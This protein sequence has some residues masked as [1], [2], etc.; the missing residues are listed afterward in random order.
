MTTVSRRTALAGGVALAAC[1]PTSVL[2]PRVKVPGASF[3]GSPFSFGVASGD[4]RSDAVVLWTALELDDARAGEDVS[5]G[6]EVA[7]D[8]FFERVLRSGVITARV[9]AGHTVKVDVTELPAGTPLFYRFVVP[10]QVSTIGK[11]KTLPAPGATPEQFRFGIGCC[12]DFRDGLFTAHRHAAAESFDAFFFLG[13]FIYEKNTAGVRQHDT[14]EPLDLAGYRARYRQYR[15]DAD[16][17]ASLAS[18]PWVLTWDDHEVVNDYGGLETPAGVVAGFSERRAAAYRAYS[19]WTPIRAAPADDSSL[20]L[21]RAFSVGQLLDVTVLDT[22]QYRSRLVCGGRSGPACSDRGRDDDSILGAAQREWL[23]ERLR[24]STASWNVMA[25]QVVF[26]DF[27][28]ANG[29]FLNHDQWDGYPAERNRVLDVLDALPSRNTVLLTG[30]IHL[31]AL[32]RVLRKGTSRASAVEIVTNSISSGGS[33]GSGNGAVIE[34]LVGSVPGFM[35]AYEGARGYTACTV[36][37]QSWQV[38]FRVVDQIDSPG[39]ALSTHASFD[40]QRDL[41]VRRR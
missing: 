10:G 41:L 38:D 26:S 9:D 21:Y 34:G 33:K 4:P 35:Y 5:V 32:S 13:D 24:A 12:Q 39:G 28:I 6:Y 30:D 1:G 20:L 7:A 16:L 31:G 18:C 37:P 17:Q 8:A 19:E 29:A 14:P 22:R 11:T 3:G 27:D 2:A 36:T 25:Q 23:F 15:R 40:L